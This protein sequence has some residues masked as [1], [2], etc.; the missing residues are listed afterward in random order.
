MK[1]QPMK[2]EKILVNHIFDKR[3]VSEIYKELR[4]L[5]T[6]TNNDVI[7]KMADGLY[8]L[9]S[10]PKQDID[11]Q[12]VLEKMINLSNHHLW[13]LFKNLKTEIQYGPTILLLGIY[14]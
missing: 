7:K 8:R 11:G 9:F 5:N 12:K 1:R 3:L 10:L 2:W 4:Q 14:I 6:T 13:Q